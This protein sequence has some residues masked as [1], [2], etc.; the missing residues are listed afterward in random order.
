M[1]TLQR[2]RRHSS[3]SQLLIKMKIVLAYLILKEIKA[4]FF[5]ILGL[6]HQDVLLRLVILEI[7]IKHYKT[8]V[9]N[10]LG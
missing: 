6:T 5:S 4:S 1:N 9:T 7:I 3:N 2:R 8:G 10:C